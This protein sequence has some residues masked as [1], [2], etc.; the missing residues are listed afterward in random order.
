MWQTV[1]A[2]AGKQNKKESY[3]FHDLC[4]GGDNGPAGRTKNWFKNAF[5]EC[6]L[7][8]G[9]CVTCCKG[10][11][12]QQKWSLSIGG[13]LPNR[14][15]RSNDCDLLISYNHWIENKTS[16]VRVQTAEQGFES[17]PASC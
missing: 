15:Q 6:Q 7:G 16:Q 12:S 2:A 14:G 10:Q 3:L 9:P 1:P 13:S 4:H 11:R 17:Q 5:I 8:T